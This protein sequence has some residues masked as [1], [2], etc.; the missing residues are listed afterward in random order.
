VLVQIWNRGLAGR[1]VI[2]DAGMMRQTRDISQLA[3]RFKDGQ[4]QQALLMTQLDRHAVFS[5]AACFVDLDSLARSHQCRGLPNRITS[6]LTCGGAF[7]LAK[8]KKQL[9]ETIGVVA[10]VVTRST[11]RGTGGPQFERF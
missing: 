7:R 1:E 10:G 3:A 8:E 5:C 11:P 4:S 6:K 2:A 9:E